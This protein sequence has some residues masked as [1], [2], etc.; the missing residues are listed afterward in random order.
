[1]LAVPLPTEPSCQPMIALNSTKITVKES[2][3]LAFTEV[4][5]SLEK[6]HASV[7]IFSKKME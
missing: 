3:Q 2:K 6:D 5:R 4:W 1:M 7:R